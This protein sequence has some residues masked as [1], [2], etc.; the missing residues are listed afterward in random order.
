MPYVIL[1][2]LCSNFTGAIPYNIKTCFT[3]FTVSENFLAPFDNFSNK[4][5]DG[6]NLNLFIDGANFVDSICEESLEGQVLTGKKL[7]IIGHLE[8][9]IFCHFP[10][11]I[12]EC[13]TLKKKLPFSTFIVVPIDVCIDDPI[14]LSYYIE[15]I[16]VTV[17]VKK[18]IFIAV[19]LLI[20]Y[21]TEYILEES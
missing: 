12:R 8:S 20:K 3:Q 7:I 21:E 15:D 19:S 10:N 18:K 9:K 11:D 1:K 2:K 16:T 5:L 4:W 6:N 17:I 13:F 14:N